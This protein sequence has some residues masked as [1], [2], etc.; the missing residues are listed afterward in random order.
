MGVSLKLVHI[1]PN[2]IYQNVHNSAICSSPKLEIPK[3]P[4]AVE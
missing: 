4:S 2:G 1:L 3:Y